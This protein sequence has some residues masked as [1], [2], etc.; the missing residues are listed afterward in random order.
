M[1]SEPK[2]RRITRSRTAAVAA[3]SASSAVESVA[4]RS[5][6][7]QFK[8]PRQQSQQN[9]K[10]KCGRNALKERN[11][12]ALENERGV[13][14]SVM[15]E[16]FG[17]IQ[18]LH[19]HEACLKELV[20]LCQDS[21]HEDFCSKLVHL[22]QIFIRNDSRS[23]FT[24][25]CIE[26]IPKLINVIDNTKRKAP[27]EENE[28]PDELGVS[29]F[30]DEVFQEPLILRECTLD[31]VL[32]AL[33]DQIESPIT[34]V[35]LNICQ[36]I[37]S[38]LATVPDIQGNLYN[39]LQDVM[40]KRIKDR[41]FA[42]RIVV[43]RI[44][45]FFQDTKRRIE[46]ENAY[47][48]H[49][50]RDP[51]FQVRYESLRSI[52]VN[53]NT[54]STIIKKIR[55]I[56]SAIRETAY[57][58]IIAQVD[59]NMLTQ[60]QR[61]YILREGLSE[62]V[63]RTRLY[64]E[65]NLL[66]AWLKGCNDDI[67]ELI[68]YI[69][70]KSNAPTEKVLKIV[71]NVYLSIKDG[72]SGTK[73]HSFVRNF[74]EKYLDEDKLLIRDHLTPKIAFLWRNL[75]EFILN[76]EDRFIKL[77]GKHF[78]SSPQSKM[79][80]S[81]ASYHEENSIQ[82][83]A[84]DY[85]E[86]SLTVEN[87]ET[88]SNPIEIRIL[89]TL[90]PELPHLC[91][92][93]SRL[94]DQ[95]EEISQESEELE[96]MQY[97]YIQLI[98]L[99]L[100]YDAGDEA[101]AGYLFD[102]IKKVLFAETLHLKLRKGISP[103]M[104]FIARRVFQDPAN[105]LEFTADCSAKVYN[106]AA[107]H[108]HDESYLTLD[109]SSYTEDGEILK[110]LEIEYARLTMDIE[111]LRDSLD[112]A[113]RSLDYQKADGLKKS[114]DELSSRRDQIQQLRLQQK[115]TPE[116]NPPVSQNPSTDFNLT[117]HPEVLLKCLEI[118]VSCLEHGN[119]STSSS[120]MIAH[121]ETI[122]LP[123]VR[124]V[125]ERIREI[126]MRGLG[127]LC[128]L[129]SATF[130]QYNNLLLMAILHDREQIKLTA[131][132]GFF[133]ALCTHGLEPIIK[134][135]EVE[136]ES[137]RVSKLEE[138]LSELTMNHLRELTALSEGLNASARE[139]DLEELR[140]MS[141]R[142]E[143][144]QT[145]DATTMATPYHP[146]KRDSETSVAS[147]LIDFFTSELLATNFPKVA[148]RSVEGFAKL[149]LLG[150]MYSPKLLSRYIMIWYWPDTDSEILQFLGVFLPVYVGSRT[151]YMQ[152]KKNITVTGQNCLIDCFMETLEI[153]YEAKNSARRDPEELRIF[154]Y[155]P[156][157]GR[158]EIHSKSVPLCQKIDLKRVADFMLQLLQPQY[159]SLLFDS[160]LKHVHDLVSNR[161]DEFRYYS[162]FIIEYSV[163]IC[164]DL[165]VGHIDQNKQKEWQEM[166]DVIV[167]KI[168]T[169]K[170]MRK[171]KSDKFVRSLKLV[172]KQI[173]RQSPSPDR[174]MSEFMTPS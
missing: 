86:R 110:N 88:E 36:L 112:E 22:I 21:C 105:L 25:N 34:Y 3:S 77:A 41:N 145:C 48:F 111:E 126:S 7:Q 66:T 19:H 46:I 94:V 38:L 18:H 55:D 90:L 91:S 92:F 115:Q 96:T 42:V 93:I 2:V 133:D 113:L 170:G 13:D 82:K 171:D 9:R 54:L 78:I 167:C 1:E 106:Y 4:I 98:E 62:R 81:R 30:G 130:H 53:E 60:E 144:D 101:Q 52:D 33:L 27:L 20:E 39:R 161:P 84:E 123:G 138:S 108:C 169:M 140:E 31:Y 154:Q 44:L 12:K 35:R 125:N 70:L 24:K 95:I 132:S 79:D 65:E 97:L 162:N 147:S 73:F 43:T 134:K 166:I 168:V 124:C 118:F 155:L 173:H 142:S 117:E 5:N 69:G 89:N 32:T 68:D 165:S 83:I 114:I 136:P 51:A 57:A 29:L 148:E 40:L 61:A 151:R 164:C 71:F 129:S 159:H 49:A 45:K 6:P 56:K 99:L 50:I 156:Y 120:S 15:V 23:P 146:L 122:I 109:Q 119:F 26:F 157:L 11:I 14:L 28:V 80:V 121:I 102:L 152:D 58:K 76:N 131:L 153:L 72:D 160:V 128:V 87:E 67:L 17:R 158:E 103:L 74:C 143:E 37:R 100:V 63:R 116:N 135:K 107:E 172:S 139:E 16:I 75:N 127:L 149:M 8:R 85:H 141:I 59:M 137:R 163:P 104:K 64:V 150:I 174:T 10:R 47:I